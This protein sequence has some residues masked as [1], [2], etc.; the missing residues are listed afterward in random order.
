MESLE[1]PTFMLDP[2]YERSSAG[3]Q[4]VY[5]ID[6]IINGTMNVKERRSNAQLN[7]Q[8]PVSPFESN[9]GGLLATTHKYD[10]HNANSNR[11]IARGNSSS[12]A[13]PPGAITIHHGG[14]EF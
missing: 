14:S 7:D 3:G 13:Y 10:G 11:S 4:G 8:S 12:H 6:E 9:F 2:Y 5:D 1:E